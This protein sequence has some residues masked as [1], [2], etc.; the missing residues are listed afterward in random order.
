MTTRRLPV[1]Q[2][3]YRMRRLGDLV[4]ESLGCPSCSLG[5]GG[6]FPHKLIDGKP[7]ALRVVKWRKTAVRLECPTCGLRFSV[8]RDGLARL[9]SEDPWALGIWWGSH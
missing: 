7:W 4:R 2:L 1:D 8:D 9:I 6:I 5:P 3:Q